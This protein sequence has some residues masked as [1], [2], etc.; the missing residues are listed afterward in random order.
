M[1]KIIADVSL[2]NPTRTTAPFNYDGIRFFSKVKC[3][4]F[5]GMKIGKGKIQ[6]I[7]Q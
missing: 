2:A 5:M 4:G 3:P 7:S 6:E 1:G